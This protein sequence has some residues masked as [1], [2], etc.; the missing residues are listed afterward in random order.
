MA[1][2]AVAS[3]LAAQ[4]RIAVSEPAALLGRMVDHL[5][6]HGDVTKDERKARFAFLLRLGRTR[7]RWQV[8]E[9]CRYGH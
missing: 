9:Y 7:D 5:S 3:E 4:A 2:T 1:D 6:E 8:S